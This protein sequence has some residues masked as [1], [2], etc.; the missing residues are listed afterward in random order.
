MADVYDGHEFI[1]EIAIFSFKGDGLRYELC[2][3]EEMDLWEEGV[4]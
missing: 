2:F 3:I 4:W 1:I